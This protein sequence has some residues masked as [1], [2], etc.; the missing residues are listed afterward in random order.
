MELCP[1]VTVRARGRRFLVVE[2]TDHGECRSVRLS[3]DS[4]DGRALT[5]L[6]PFD[7]LQVLATADRLKR[8]SRRRVARCCAAAVRQSHA[9]GQTRTAIDAHIDLMPYQIEPTLAVLHG[10]ATR[11]LL[12]DEVG[13]GKT[14]QAG[15]IL[16]ELRARQALRRALVL[17][18]A[19]LREQWAAE[20]RGRFK[21]EAAIV[22]AGEL[23]VAERQLPPWVNP[24][25]VPG[26]A[27][28]SIDLI[29]RREVLS[30]IEHVIWDAAVVDEAHHAAPG[31]DRAAAASLVCGR[32][33][34][35][36]L[37]TAT[38]HS[39]DRP[40]F[41]HLCSLGSLHD[42][43]P[44]RIFRRRR[45]DVWPEAQARR[46]RLVRVAR[47]PVERRLDHA[48]RRY[49]AKVWRES[50]TGADE[51]SGA[52]LAMVVLRKRALSGPASL[53][54]SLARRLDALDRRQAGPFATQLPLAFEDS[55]D[56]DLI[57]DDEEPS[58]DLSAPGLRDGVAE[59]AMLQDLLERA[60]A[61]VGCDSKAERLV[62]AVTASCE[63]VIVFTEYRDT[64][65]DLRRRLE[66]RA[67]VVL[68]HGALLP[69]ERRAAMAAFQ[70]GRARVLL[71]TDAAAEGLNLHQR[72]RWLVHHEVPW[73]PVRIEQRNGRVDR[74]GQA[75]RVHVWH[76]VAQQTEEENVLAR[77]ARRSAAAAR[78]LEDDG[79]I[80]RAV[81]DRAALPSDR[82]RSPR[83]VAGERSVAEAARVMLLRRLRAGWT[84]AS[85]LVDRRVARAERMLAVIRVIVLDGQTR[86]AAIECIG[87]EAPSLDA[88]R[89][90]ARDHASAVSARSVEIDRQRSHAAAERANAI[91]GALV[92][93][94][95]IPVQVPLFDRRALARAEHRQAELRRA[96]AELRDISG[97]PARYTI[98]T[99]L[100]GVLAV[101]HKR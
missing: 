4:A 95:T 85:P 45:E 68:L 8:A 14:V 86:T 50:A 38:P 48:L 3:P 15:L 40:A 47:T 70:T 5:L 9:A 94:G 93:G 87:I 84:D 75:R 54:R 58:G 27:I 6:E 67:T 88:C 12:A 81:F 19:G 55:I 60:R 23:A 98:K 64:L 20:L 74:L 77:L 51:V 35:V 57:E 43:R 72:C 1:S 73:S 92:E 97:S 37:V 7:R 71:A 59:R 13:L 30:Q 39:G 11:I 66:G 65:E 91:R 22:D 78:D 44:I 83:P 33:R 28:A 63:P 32:A 17:T 53:A 21:L 76:L 31:T 10:E 100:I 99:S 24:W 90:A 89:N 79:V 49:T 61:A 80:A 16:S 96:L 26:V 62:T 18:P 56:G 52:R 36:V 101:S 69:P 82:P 29:K 41:E 42:D 46:T 25:A 2:I 34:V